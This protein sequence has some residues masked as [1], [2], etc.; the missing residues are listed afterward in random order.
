MF[1]IGYIF[2]F[3]TRFLNIYRMVNIGSIVWCLIY[4]IQFVKYNSLFISTSLLLLLFY[5][6]IIRNNSFTH[7]PSPLQALILFN[8]FRE[9]VLR[10]VLLIHFNVGIPKVVVSVLLSP[11]KIPFYNLT[12][13]I[14]LRNRIE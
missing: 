7:P 13:F 1:S 2:I 3:S 14:Y 9:M 10:V 8:V 5:Y 11:F 4:Y 6:N 12:I